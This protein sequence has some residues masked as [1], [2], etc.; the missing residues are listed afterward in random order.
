[1]ILGQHYVIF[2]V[3]CFTSLRH[4]GTIINVTITTHLFDA[5]VSSYCR[6]HIMKSSSMPRRPATVRHT[7]QPSQTVCVI[8]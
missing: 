5:Y 7:P 8:E 1:M 4:M 6:P 3:Y 2:F